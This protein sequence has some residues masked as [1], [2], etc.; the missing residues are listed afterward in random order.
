M[1]FSAQRLLTAARLVPVRTRPRA[2]ALSTSCLS[3]TAGS[4]T[5][6]ATTAHSGGLVALQ[7]SSGIAA[8]NGQART[9]AASSAAGPVF[10]QRPLDASTSP[11]PNLLTPA[12]A[13]AFAAALAATGVAVHGDDGSLA[14]CSSEYSGK[15]VDPAD[16]AEHRQRVDKALGQLKSQFNCSMSVL[17]NIANRMDKEMSRGLRKTEGSEIKMLPSYV[18]GVP[19]GKEEGKFL[20]L[21]LGGSNFRVVAFGLSPSQGVEL[22]EARKVTIPAELMTSDSDASELFG[23]IADQVGMAPGAK[24]KSTPNLKLGFTFS[25]PVDQKSINE[26]NLVHWTKGFSTRDCEGEEVV[27]LLQNAFKERDISVDVSA[28]VN[29]TVGTL[30]AHA[31]EDKRTQVGVILGTGCNACYVEKVGNILKLDDTSGDPD[32][33]MVSLEILVYTGT[34]RI[35]CASIFFPGAFSN[36][37]T[38]CFSSPHSHNLTN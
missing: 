12:L 38:P 18:S 35:P 28:L 21:D 20:A 4:L 23:F 14:A 16:S 9:F 5:A 34:G 26:G 33:S 29:D 19:S 17:N 13:A 15:A 11:S 24:D 30:V 2:A 36:S 31:V 25:F 10:G 32:A 27:Q 3:T 7:S 22:L 37:M 8:T 6:A 1:Y